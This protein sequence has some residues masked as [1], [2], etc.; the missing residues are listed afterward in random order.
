MLITNIKPE[1]ILPI[2]K[3]VVESW[4][5]FTTGQLVE[6]KPEKTIVKIVR[7]IEQFDNP[8][9]S[10]QGEHTARFDVVYLSGLG[11]NADY[12]HF[13][14]AGYINPSHDF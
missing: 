8:T 4:K 6:F 5:N 7:I 14:N 9:N 11:F 12:T 1:D 10:W 2:N 13:D 3:R